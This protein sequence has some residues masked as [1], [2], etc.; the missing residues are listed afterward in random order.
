MKL[1]SNNVY[2]NINSPRK[3]NENYC[4]LQVSIFISG[5]N[6]LHLKKYFKCKTYL[7]FKYFWPRMRDLHYFWV[8]LI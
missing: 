2:K 5:A 4:F 1:G 7:Q 8:C 6:A 3:Q